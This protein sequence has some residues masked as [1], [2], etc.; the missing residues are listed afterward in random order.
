[1]YIFLFIIILILII[2]NIIITSMLI[3]NSTYIGGSKSTD[4]TMEIKDKV[5][6]LI[7]YTKKLKQN[8]NEGDLNNY[9][10]NVKNIKKITN[11]ILNK[12]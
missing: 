3:Q 4:L 1:M 8:P 10:T 12:L 11:K 5:E 7:T 9:I 6:N 2:C